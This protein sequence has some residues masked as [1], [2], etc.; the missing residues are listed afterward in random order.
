MS[1]LPTSLRRSVPFCR[2]VQRGVRVVIEHKTVIIQ[3]GEGIQGVDQR[4]IRVLCVS[5]RDGVP[6]RPATCYATVDL[7]VGSDS[8]GVVR[9]TNVYVG[10]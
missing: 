8:F 7:F 3:S 6:R 9:Q 2:S 4:N 5:E 10:A 1:E